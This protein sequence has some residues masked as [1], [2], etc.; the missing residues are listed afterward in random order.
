MKRIKWNEPSGLITTT[1][2]TAATVTTRTTT[3]A[4]NMRPFKGQAHLMGEL[5]ICPYRW[6][7]SITRFSISSLIFRTFAIGFPLGSGRSWV[8]ELL[9]HLGKH[10]PGA[11]LFNRATH[12]HDEARLANHFAR[13]HLG[14]VGREVYPLLLHGLDDYGI[15]LR[16]GTVPALDAFNPCLFANAS[17]I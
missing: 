2:I 7:S 10:R 1:T 3:T 14:S 15:D 6:E 8:Y 17:A 12:G 11:Y 13:Q 5:P 9:L 4:P 16:D